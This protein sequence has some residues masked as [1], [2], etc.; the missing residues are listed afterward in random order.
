MARQTFEAYGRR[1]REYTDLL[2]S[3]S[4]T[5]AE[6]RA[7]VECW[8]SAIDGPVLDVGCGPGHWTAWLHQLGVDIEGIDPVQEFVDIAAH[9]HPDCA[10]RQGT[11]EAL[12]V[13]SASLSGALVW[14]SLIHTEPSGL[15]AALAELA[16]CIRPGGRL[17]VGFF[18]GPAVERRARLSQASAQAAQSANHHGRPCRAGDR[19]G[20]PRDRRPVATRR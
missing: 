14:Y 16:R 1:A 13:P 12:G 15:P 2:G 9:R 11:A 19:G 3:I 17:L 7:L 8:A 20:W 6:D 5:A 10:Y 18:E 4:A